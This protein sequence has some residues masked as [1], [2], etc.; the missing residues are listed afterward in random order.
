MI[1][2]RNQKSLSLILRKAPDYGIEIFPTDRKRQT[3]VITEPSPLFPPIHDPIWH[4]LT[5]GVSQKS[6]TKAAGKYSTRCGTF[7]ILSLCFVKCI[8]KRNKTCRMQNMKFYL[9][10]I[11]KQVPPPSLGCADN[12]SPKLS[13]YPRPTCSLLSPFWDR[14]YNDQ[15]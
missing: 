1:V 15:H 14:D 5:C 9:L 7:N 8:P 4:L 10:E 13:N 11:I 2:I 3:S 12:L 6:I